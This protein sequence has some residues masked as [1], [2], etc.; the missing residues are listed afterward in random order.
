MTSPATCAHL[1]ACR[2]CLTRAAALYSAPPI[3]LQRSGDAV[4]EATATGDG[5]AWLCLSC[6]T[7]LGVGG[8]APAH[9]CEGAA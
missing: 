9:R 1:K 5:F 8:D 7:A 4:L 2:G 3:P 6:A